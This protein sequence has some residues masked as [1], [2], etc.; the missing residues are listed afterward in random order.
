[1]QP[2]QIDFSLSSEEETK[3]IIILRENINL[4]AWKPTDMPNVDPNIV[5]HHPALDPAIKLIAQR[6]RKEGEEK[7]K[8]VEDEFKKLMK[9]NFIKEIR[10]PT[11]LA[12]IIMVKKKSGN[13]EYM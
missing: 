12:N 8:V 2:N 6:K 10:Y 7:R 9:A 4:F 3:I 1:M 11:Q 13:G 5:C